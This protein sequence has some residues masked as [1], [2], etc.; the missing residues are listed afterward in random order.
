MTARTFGK[1]GQAGDDGEIARRREAF[2][3]SERARKAQLQEEA[4]MGGGRSAEPV[5]AIVIRE[6][7]LAV[8]YILWFFFG[9]ISAHRFYL[10]HSVSAAIQASL[11]LVSWLMV[12]GGFFLAL[13][14]LLAAA[15]WIFVDIFL[16]PSLHASANSRARKQAVQY[17][18]T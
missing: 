12:I 7:S 10:G 17:V 16:M 11:W 5:G 14:V 2:L 13:P 9:A 15:L 3:A 8:A 18:F 4:A 6:K 1:K